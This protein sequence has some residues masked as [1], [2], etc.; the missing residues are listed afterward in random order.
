MFNVIKSLQLEGLRELNFQ[1][2]AG[3]KESQKET[4]GTMSSASSIPR[5]SAEEIYESYDLGNHASQ[6]K[7]CYG[8]L[9]GSDGRS[10][11]FRHENLPEAPPSVEI[12]MTS[13]PAGNETSLSRKP[14]ILDKMCI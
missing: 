4:S 3:T 6:I 13:Y 14:C 1:D 5:D 8:T 10:F 2:F 12:T 9:S 11:R 7:S